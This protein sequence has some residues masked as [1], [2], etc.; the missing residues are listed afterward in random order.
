LANLNLH[1]GIDERSG[2]GDTGHRLRN[3]N[4]V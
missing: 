3:E 1:L 2:S 4:S